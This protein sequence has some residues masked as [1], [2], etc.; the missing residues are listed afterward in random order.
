M[1][2]TSKRRARRPGDLFPL[3]APYRTGRLKVSALHTLRYEEY[4][5]PRGRPLVF[6]HGGPGAGFR[7]KHRRYFDPRVWRVALFDQTSFSKYLL[8][9]PGE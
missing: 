3:R 2:S 9:G 1:T 4:G 7:P 5:H 6:L 8:T